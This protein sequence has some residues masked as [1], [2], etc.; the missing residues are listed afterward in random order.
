MLQ[1]LNSRFDKLI[2]Q[3]VFMLSTFLDPNIGINY[4]EEKHQDVV[5]ARVLAILKREQASKQVKIK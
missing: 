4:F 2:V 3:E 1:S 5:T